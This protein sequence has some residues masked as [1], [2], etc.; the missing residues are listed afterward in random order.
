MKQAYTLA[1]DRLELLTFTISQ[2]DGQAQ[3]R[4]TNDLIKKLETTAS[5]LC[6]MTNKYEDAVTVVKEKVH[7][8]TQT[9]GATLTLFSD[10]NDKI[11]I[12]SK[13]QCAICIPSSF[14]FCIITNMDKLTEYSCFQI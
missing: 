12:L 4:E 10:H 9:N 1:V 3:V 11:L 2:P 14:F 8:L 5:E 7:A 6:D 13:L